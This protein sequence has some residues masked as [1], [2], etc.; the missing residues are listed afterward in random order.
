MGFK[1]FPK[2]IR[3]SRSTFKISQKN[4]SCLMDI[5][6]FRKYFR[7]SHKDQ[8]KI[9]LMQLQKISIPD[10]NIF[11]WVKLQ[12][13][14]SISEIENTIDSVRAKDVFSIDT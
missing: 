5:Y 1:A 11:A 7:R 2:Y 8:E 13:G 9:I 6:K 12:S 14:Y 3:F 10:L 4:L